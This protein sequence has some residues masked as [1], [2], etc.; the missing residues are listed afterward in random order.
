MNIIH[1]AVGVLCNPH[2]EILFAQRPT[3][4]PM[5]GYWEFPGGKLEAGESVHAALARELHEELGIDIGA[6]TH[7]RVVEHVYPHAH[8]LL[9][10]QIIRE[11]TGEPHGREAQA[12]C[13]QRLDTVHTQPILPATVPLL[14]DLANFVAI[15]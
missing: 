15:V 9:H 10:F 4:K 13:W 7:W 11:W 5:A 6:S 1:V 14:D 2:G 8:V 3:G 12:L